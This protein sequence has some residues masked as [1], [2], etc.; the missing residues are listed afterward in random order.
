[1]RDIQ[2]TFQHSFQ[3]GVENAVE[4]FLKKYFTWKGRFKKWQKEKR[5]A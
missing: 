2:H 1:V 4:N 3:H 5:E